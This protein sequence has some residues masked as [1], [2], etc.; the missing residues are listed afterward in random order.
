[1]RQG[2]LQTNARCR[3]RAGRP[4]RRTHGLARRDLRQR[5]HGANLFETAISKQ[6]NRVVALPE[7]NK[8]ILSNIEAAD[9]PGHQELHALGVRPGAT[10]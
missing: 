5:A 1:M 2:R 10:S 9:I 8:E 6:A 4:L 3:D 7:V